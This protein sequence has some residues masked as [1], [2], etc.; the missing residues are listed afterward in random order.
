MK[1]ELARQSQL[2]EILHKEFEEHREQQREKETLLKGEI[3]KLEIYKSRQNKID[4][5]IDTLNREK[6]QLQEKNKNLEKYYL[7]LVQ[8]AEEF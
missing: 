6:K 7:K 2:Y 3:S 5:E 1:N 4:I 8:N